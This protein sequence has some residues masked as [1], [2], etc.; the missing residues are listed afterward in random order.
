MIGRRIRRAT[1]LGMSLL[2]VTATAA[3]ADNLDDTLVTGDGLSISIEEGQSFSTTVTYQ[4]EKTGANNTSFPATVNFAL[5][6]VGASTV[7]SWAS[8]NATSLTFT[9]YT[10]SKTITL[11]GTA[12]SGSAGDSHTFR[13]VPST[14]APNLNVVNAQVQFTVVVTEASF[15]NSP[16]VITKAVFDPAT[17]GC[18]TDNATLKVEWTDEDAGDTHTVS[19]NWGDGSSVQN[20]GTQ[21]SA[22]QASHTY[23][24]AATYTATVTVSDGTDS[25]AETATVTVLYNTSGILQPI[26][27]DGTSLFKIGQTIPVKAVFTNCDGSLPTNNPTVHLSKISNGLNGDEVVETLVSSSAADTGNQM[28]YSTEGEQ[29]IFNLSTKKSQFNGG[30]DLSEGRYRLTIK[31]DGITQFSVEFGLRK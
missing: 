8:L 24:A 2:M 10:D 14:S 7:P 23:A 19:V 30:K 12:P 11:S 16:P 3:W 31:I 26:N 6:S 4:V 1:A 15:V 5:S 21:T 18:G 9:G 25:D 29:Y 20:F 13:I 17:V 28:R 22:F 27:P